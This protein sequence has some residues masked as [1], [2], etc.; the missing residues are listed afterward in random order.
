MFSLD[1]LPMTYI[2]STEAF[3]PFLSASVLEEEP[4]LAEKLLCYIIAKD[5]LFSVF[6]IY[7]EK[8]FIS[9]DKRT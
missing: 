6:D 3:L 4:P 1:F 5:P 2:I 8:S 7:W 9:L